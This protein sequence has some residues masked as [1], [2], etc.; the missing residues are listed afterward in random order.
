MLLR[1]CRNG[2]PARWVVLVEDELYGEY[3]DKVQA[4]LDARNQTISAED[5]RKLGPAMI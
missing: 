3:T 1:V 4:F 5:R 2:L